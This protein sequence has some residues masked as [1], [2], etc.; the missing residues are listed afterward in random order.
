V[1]CIVREYTS[2]RL[3]KGRQYLRSKR[4]HANSENPGYAYGAKWNIKYS[5]VGRAT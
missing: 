4:V 5:I 1:Y 3:E 2:C